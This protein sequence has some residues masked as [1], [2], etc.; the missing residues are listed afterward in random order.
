MPDPI[1][2]AIEELKTIKINLQHAG[3]TLDNNRNTQ[4]SE[5]Q[6]QVLKLAAEGHTSEESAT[7]V[8]RS[9]R[10]VEAIRRDLCCI[11]N[12]RNVT[13]AVWIAAKRGLLE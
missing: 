6:L 5:V 10:T 9:R 1:E 4:L 3:V 2:I 11:L 12:A 8:F 7:V 13:Q